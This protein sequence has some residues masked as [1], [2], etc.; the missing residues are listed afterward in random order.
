MTGLALP[1]PVRPPR[2]LGLELLLFSALAAFGVAQ[3]ARLV[4]DPPLGRFL[5]VLAIVAIVA[6]ALAMVAAAQ[7]PAARR[8][9]LALAIGTLGTAAAMVVVGLPARFLLPA[10]WGELGSQIRGGLSGIEESELPYGGR[11]VWVRLTLLLGVP[12]L[13]GL[14]AA[15]SFWPARRRRLARALGLAALVTIYGIAA[16]L[17]DPGQEL[18]WGIPL[19]VLCAAWMWVPGLDSRRARR[20]LAVVGCAGVVALPL[21]A[22]LDGA[23]SG[24]NWESWTLFTHQREVSFDWNHTYGP[25][26]WPQEG[27]KLFEAR[28]VRPLYWKTSVLDRF[29]GTGWERASADDPQAA[30]E[31]LARHHTPGGNLARR[32][33]DWLTQASVQVDALS[34][35]F[36]IGSGTTQVVQGIGGVHPSL[37]GT[38]TINGA[39]LARDQ[40]YSI[41][42]YSPRPTSA[43]LQRAPASYP[44]R[45]FGGST[46][47]GLPSAD[48]GAATSPSAADQVVA[49]PTWGERDPVASQALL[50]SPYARV[51]RLA[52][53]LVADARTPYQA[54]GTIEAHL[55]QRYQ[56]SPDVPA[57]DFPLPAFLFDDRAGYCQQFSGAMALMLRMVGVPSRV[58]AGFAPGTYDK[59]LGT[60]V[61]RDYDAHS[62]VEAYFRGIGWV[63]F[64]PTPPTAPAAS[65]SSGVGLGDL[66]RGG[67]IFAIRDVG[68]RQTSGGAHGDRLTLTTSSSRAGGPWAAVGLVSLA[69][70]ALAGAAALVVF[71]RR[72]RVLESGAA[73]PAQLDELRQA[74][75]RLGARLSPNPTLLAIERRY[76]RTGRA[77]IA[78]YAKALR[79]HRYAP[80]TPGPPG[81]AA[82]R[83]LRRAL[84]SSGLGGWLRA[85]AAIPP[86]GPRTSR[87]S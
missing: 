45:R 78:D 85:L 9:L 41:V 27:T 43:Q 83:A 50:S 75:D 34:S 14:A 56:Y 28:T 51:Y 70:A 39:P 13:L 80:G 6:L 24:W 67:G 47:I 29:T 32:N 57:H 20:T 72:R 66:R 5:A 4:A 68:R 46:L 84:S 81:A 52:R 10:N 7:P 61:V 12:L 71:W 16:T 11:D 25:L 87:R 40:E 8:R 74:L 77:A 58:V 30:A 62:W 21:A 3:W 42:V 18:L 31:R 2:G 73:A 54:V 35:E 65:Q 82:R 86:G 15:A 44:E 59:T 17:D 33:G 69:I 38:L 26:N 36:A 48:A 79:A 49:M 55:R 53:R 63:T 19:L 60:Y 64:D 1:Q 76:G 23:I 22:R 37:D